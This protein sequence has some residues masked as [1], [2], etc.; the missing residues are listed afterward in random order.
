MGIKPS[1]AK[2][3][4]KIAIRLSM[5]LNSNFEYFMKMPILELMEVVEEVVEVGQ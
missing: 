3:I 5:K 2:A 4:R 1:D